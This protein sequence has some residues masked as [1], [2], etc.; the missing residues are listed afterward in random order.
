[1]K[2]LVFVFISNFTSNKG[3]NSYLSPTTGFSQDLT[4]IAIDFNFDIFFCPI[5]TGD[6]IWYFPSPFNFLIAFFRN[7]KFPTAKC[8]FDVSAF[9]RFLSRFTLFA[10][11]DLIAIKF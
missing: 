5:R 4:S 1:M 10:S 7:I 2:V 3:A 8:V 11:L 6:L 9:F